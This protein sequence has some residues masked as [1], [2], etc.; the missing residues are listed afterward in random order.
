MCNHHTPNSP[1]QGF[2]TAATSRVTVPLSPIAKLA[3]LPLIT[4]IKLYRL[5]GSPIVGG[6]CRFS[7]TCS[8]YALEALRLHGPI[9]GT[10]MTTKRIT[11]CTPW[12]KGGF[13]PVPIPE[14]AQLLP[15]TK[16]PHDGRKT[17]SS[18]TP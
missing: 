12:N 11:R 8:I 14:N 2:G 9:R 17:P 5:V 6:Q 18:T 13:D 10:W 1:D 4:L 16:E 3:N 15:H 7:P